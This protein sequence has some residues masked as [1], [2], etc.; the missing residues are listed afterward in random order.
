[1]G[2]V[3]TSEFDWR[4][5][6]LWRL[7]VFDWARSL[8]VDHELALTDGTFQL[9]GGREPRQVGAVALTHDGQKQHEMPTQKATATYSV[10]GA[11]LGRGSPESSFLGIALSRT[12]YVIASS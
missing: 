1:M 3:R 11:R 10:P 8:L 6:A 5:C 2:E 9:G 7:S 4:D 12:G